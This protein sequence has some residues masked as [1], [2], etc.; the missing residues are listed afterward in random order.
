MKWIFAVAAAVILG[1]TVSTVVMA[2]ELTQLQ[3]QVANIPA[4]PI[5]PQGASGEPGPEGPQGQQGPEGPRGPQGEQGPM[6]LEGP[7]G[8]DSGTLFGS[9]DLY[10]DSY[11]TGSISITLYNCREG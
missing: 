2:V 11:F 5:G 1:L 3:G 10:C 7:A 9:Y 4:G 6:G 8:I